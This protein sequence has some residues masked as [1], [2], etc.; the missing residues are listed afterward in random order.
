MR[1][2]IVYVPGATLNL[3]AGRNIFRLNRL[4]EDFPEPLLLN[5]G[6]GER[7]IGADALSERVLQKMVS[8]DLFAYPGTRVVGDAHFLPF[9]D[10]AF[11][12][13][14]C[15]A[16]LEHTRRPESVVEETRR[17]LKRGGLVYA[18]VPFLQGYH[19]TPRD[20]RRFTL[21]GLEELFSGFA[22]I[23]SGVCVGPSSSVSWLLREYI[24][25]LLTGFTPSSPLRAPAAIAAGWLTFSIKYLDFLFARRPG[26][27]A[28]ASGLYFFGRKG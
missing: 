14:I 18:E 13:A 17:V 15:Q 3:A 28:I 8:F 5:L 1:K 10:D 9:G 21:E 7:F 4:L 22:R 27:Q 25:G 23:D 12:A 19:P 26:A 20:Y 2:R 11:H 16:V 6:S 24:T